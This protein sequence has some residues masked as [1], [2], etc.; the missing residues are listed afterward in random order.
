[1]NVDIKGRPVSNPFDRVIENQDK[2]YEELVRLNT[3]LME[4][5]S[6]MMRAYKTIDCG[7]YQKPEIEKDMAI[8]KFPNREVMGA[9][10]MQMERLY[11]GNGMIRRTGGKLGMKLKPETYITVWGLRYVLLCETDKEHE[12][13]MKTNPQIKQVSYSDAKCFEAFLVRFYRG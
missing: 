7:I 3:N 2:H 10:L 4:K 13:Y 1:M 11:W 6:D 12:R 8:W 5:M 9:V